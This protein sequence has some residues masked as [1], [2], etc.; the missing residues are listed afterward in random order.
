MT[1]VPK[2]RPADAIGRRFAQIVRRPIRSENRILLALLAFGLAI[3]I[4]VAVGQIGIIHPDETF[5]YLEQG[6]RLAFGSGVVPWE[7]IYGVRSWLLPSLVAA[8]MKAS[9]WFSSD[10]LVYI[11]SLRGIAAALSLTTIY[12]AFHIVRPRSGLIWATIAGF[13][14][15]TWYHAIFLSPSI[16]TEVLAAYLMLPAIF[17]ADQPSPGTRG[18]HDSIVIGLLLG[19]AFCLRF[20]M[21]PALFAIACWHC[22]TDYKRKWPTLLVPATVVV[23]VVSGLLDWVTLGSP[24]QSVWLNFDLNA[25]KGVSS[26]FGREPWFA[27]FDTIAPAGALAL[28]AIVWLAVIGAWRAPLLALTSLIVLVS[29]SLFAHKE[30]RFIAFALVTLPILTALGAAALAERLR[31]RAGP[32]A[33]MIATLIVSIGVPTISGF[34]WQRLRE[35]KTVLNAGVLDAF[36][37]AHGQTKLCALGVP[38]YWWTNTGGYTYVNRDVPIYYSRYLTPGTGYRI[39]DLKGFSLGTAR[40]A[41]PMQMKVVLDH[42][43]IA[44]YPGDSLLKNTST[45]N[46][47]IAARGR[48]LP[49]FSTVK[50]FANQPGSLWPTACLLHRDGGCRER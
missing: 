42:Q 16:L 19:L 8:V 24:F 45:F 4:G 43:P 33:A 3:R 12:F 25:I 31:V 39:Y 6:H 23:G 18:K 2:D 40:G 5:Q 15:A 30:Y 46:Y 38:D 7:Y 35:E 29:H 9:S 13:F 27:Y 17:L 49:G 20:Q 21:A 11:Y 10:P 50:C 26:S 41:I 32:R 14:C 22:R 44:Q 1:A 48:S 28:L 34:E 36:I 37:A 47:A